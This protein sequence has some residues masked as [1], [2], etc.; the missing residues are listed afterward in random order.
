M[1][2]IA[3]GMADDIFGPGLTTRSAPSAW[4]LRKSG[5]AQVLST[6]TRCFMPMGDRGD[7]RQVL[8]LEGERARQFDID[9][10]RLGPEQ[11]RRYPRQEA[12]RRRSSR[13]RAASGHRVAK[14]GASGHRRCRPSGDGRPSDSTL[15]R[16]VVTAESPEGQS[17]TPALPSRAI[18]ASSSPR[19]SACR[20]CRRRRAAWFLEIRGPWAQG[21]SSRDRR[22]GFTKPWKRPGRGPPTTRRVFSPS[23]ARSALLIFFMIPGAPTSLGRD[24]QGRSGPRKGPSELGVRSWYDKQLRNRWMHRCGRYATYFC[25]TPGEIGHAIEAAGEIGPEEATRRRSKHRRATVKRGKSMKTKILALTLGTVLAIGATAASAATLDTVKQRGEL[26]CGSNTGL[27]G[28]GI[29]NDKG[30]W[31][32]FDVDYCRAVATAIFNDPEEGQVRP[33]LGQG[34]RRPPCNRARSTSS[35]A[36]PPGRCRARPRA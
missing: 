3:S 24:N 26:I 23:S 8:H 15:S 7:G 35:S 19:R 28:F 5:V 36:T 17:I 10:P 25:L 31:T 16:A 22:A 4:A 20:A 13:C 9:G 12:G 33:A 2:N 21:P 32:G 27:A 6:T 14:R 18:S 30:E 29:P 34:P 11:A 1:P